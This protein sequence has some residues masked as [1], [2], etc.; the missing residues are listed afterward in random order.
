MQ[1]RTYVEGGNS[2]APG[3]DLENGGGEGSVAGSNF[4]AASSAD[5]GD[6]SFKTP[7]NAAHNDSSQHFAF[8]H[9]E[10]KW[11]PDDED[12]DDSS[13]RD[14][15]RGGG[16]GGGGAASM[17]QAGEWK[18]ELTFEDQSASSSLG[19]AVRRAN[20]TAGTSDGPYGPDVHVGKSVPL[21][22]RSLPGEEQ[23]LSLHARVL[24][25]STVMYFFSCALQASAEAVVGLYFLFPSSH[26]GL[27]YTPYEVGT[28]ALVVSTLLIVLSTRRQLRRVSRLPTRA[29]LRAFRIGE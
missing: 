11:V 21:N 28:L 4:S 6:G 19:T 18:T 22:A 24:G 13:R 10:Q 5:T 7:T 12:D 25:I 23:S 20:A 16:G 14:G 3:D 2:G 26:G 17:V 27:G 15:P 9:V 29:P 8:D 1:L